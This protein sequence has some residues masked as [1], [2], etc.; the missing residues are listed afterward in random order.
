M[1]TR[2][3][4]KGKETWDLDKG[5]HAY[6]ATAAKQPLV[7]AGCL[8]GHRQLQTGDLVVPDELVQEGGD[9]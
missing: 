5:G 1:R 9:R 8:L 2:A 6:S 4:K 7:P 3:R